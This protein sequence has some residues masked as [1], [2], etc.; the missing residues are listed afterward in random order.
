MLSQWNLICIHRNI[1]S[2]KGV[3]CP[4]TM[5][6]T[7]NHPQITHFYGRIPIFNALIRMI[8]IRH[9]EALLYLKLKWFNWKIVK[10]TGRYAFCSA[11][12]IY[13][14]IFLL[15]LNWKCNI[16]HIWLCGEASYHSIFV[17]ICWLKA[18]IFS[19]LYL[20]VS[21]YNVRLVEISEKV[22][23]IT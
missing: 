1:H 3:M 16:S 13:I 21:I 15:W 19:K 5:S 20:A 12:I 14:Y 9:H 17:C 18:P 4:A 8:L 11:Y 2:S 6:S 23:L 22:I 10:E 7:I